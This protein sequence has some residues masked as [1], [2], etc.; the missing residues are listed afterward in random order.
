M[1]KVIFYCGAQRRDCCIVRQTPRTRN[2]IHDCTT[3]TL[4]FNSYCKDKLFELKCF[5]YE[6][7]AFLQI[8]LDLQL[9]EAEVFNSSLGLKI[10]PSLLCRF[11]CETSSDRSI[12]VY[13]ASLI[14]TTIN[15][16]YIATRL[17]Q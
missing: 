8:R 6:T 3:L 2:E 14:W 15:C 1:T 13:F 4:Y 17:P 11:S 5:F 12:L 9:K 16:Y 7:S 10:S